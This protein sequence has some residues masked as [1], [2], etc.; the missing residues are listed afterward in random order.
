MG[1]KNP[2]QRRVYQRRHRAKLKRENPQ[3][4]YRQRAA[5]NIKRYGLT[6]DEFEAALIASK[7]LCAICRRPETIKQKGV[8]QRL[9]IDHNHETGKFRGLLCKRCN[10]AVGQIKDDPLVARSMADYLERP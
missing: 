3:K 2:E 8:L 4:Y 6:V 10:T 7:G 5:D 9:S 1:L